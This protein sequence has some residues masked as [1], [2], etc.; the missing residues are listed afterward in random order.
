[1]ITKKK[2]KENKMNEIDNFIKERQ[3]RT[4]IRIN[5]LK[6]ILGLIITAMINK[7]NFPTKNNEF[8]YK[9]FKKE[10]LYAF[11]IVYNRNRYNMK[12]NKK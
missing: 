5:V 8:N 7:D 6:E 3:E 1:M 11:E 12:E 2:I 4:N 9:R 10:L